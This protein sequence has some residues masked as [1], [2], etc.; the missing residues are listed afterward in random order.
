MIAATC[1]WLAVH[2]CTP[3]D[4][5]AVELS[6]KF[7]PRSSSIEDK[8][9]D[10]NSGKP[11]TGAIER[12]RLD[13][14]VAGERGEES[15]LCDDS[16]GVTRFELPPGAALLTVTPIC[17]SG[18]ALPASFIAPAAEQRTVTVGDTVSLGA[19]ELVVQVSECGQASCICE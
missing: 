15:W 18:P 16:H 10:C 6:W 3:V 2:G 7:R 1:L 13:W 8:F 5:G 19:V 17:A 12:I 4:G 14:D 11:G 9:V